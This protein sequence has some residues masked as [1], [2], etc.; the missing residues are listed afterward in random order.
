M[1][2]DHHLW[3]KGHFGQ[4]VGLASERGPSAMARR[5][6][7]QKGQSREYR[8]QIMASRASLGK[9][10]V[11]RG[12]VWAKRSSREYRGPQVMAQSQ[13]G[14]KVVRE[15]VAD[16]RTWLVTSHHCGHHH[17]SSSWAKRSAVI[18]VG[19]TTGHHVIIIVG[20]HG[21]RVVRAR[22]LDHQVWHRC[23]SGQEVGL[24]SIADRQ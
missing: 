10:V 23:Q 16:H 13:Y 8:P 12:P 6:F 7:G 5:P 9:K 20:C 21:Q 3:L 2:A 17:R 24:A 14:Q 18:I 19:T 22:E 15:S 11:T 1:I 4:K